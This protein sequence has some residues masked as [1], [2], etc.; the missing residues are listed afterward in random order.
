MALK[1]LSQ[2][3]PNV[4]SGKTVLV[5][6][7]FNV[8]FTREKHGALRITDV[9]RI[10]AAVPTIKFLSSA[11]ARVIIVTHMGRPDGYDAGLTLWPVALACA[12]ITQ[13]EVHFIDSLELG[14]FA[15][16]VSDYHPGDIFLLENMRFYAGEEKNSIVFARKLAACADAYVNDAFSV[17]HRRHASVDRIT[18]LLPSYAGLLME[19]EMRALQKV[20]KARA[21]SLVAVMG[22]SKLSTKVPVIAG[23]SKKAHGVL[24]G[25]AL[26]TA[27][28]QVQGYSVGK[29]TPDNESIRAA[30]KLKKI[31]NIITPVDVVV[32]KSDGRGVRVVSIDEL[33][34]T[35]KRVIARATE[36]VYDIGPRTIALYAQYVRR[37]KT[38]LWNGP[39]GLCEV[40]AYCHGSRALGHYIAARARGT[41]YCVVGGGE[42][43]ELIR[44]MGVERDIDWVS[45][46]GGA[47]LEYLAQGTL[48][49]IDALTRSRKKIL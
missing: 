44:H 22:G 25:S 32:G 10:E 37:A 9:S 46:S 7:D 12:R 43:V 6:V 17:S 21:Q 41:T 26:S 36:G 39:L 27:L 18:T 13:K 4:W 19:Q 45:M 15:D 38:L 8:P 31:T 49:G 16:A 20:P 48:P 28:W 33:A 11:G 47:M 42:T 40:H 24:L 1:F 30:Q 5:R 34:R 23:V 2:T 29:S 14:L 3:S 35:G